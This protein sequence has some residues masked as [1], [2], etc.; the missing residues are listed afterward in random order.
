MA[1]RILITNADAASEVPG[2]SLAEVIKSRP[3]VAEDAFAILRS[4]AV[5]LDAMHAEGRVHGALRPESVV[6][7][8]GLARIVDWDAGNALAPLEHLVHAAEYLAPERL[9]GA[10]ASP[11]ADQFTLGAIAYRMRLGRSP[12]AAISLAETLFLIRYG[13]VDPDAYEYVDFATQSVFD[14]IFS[15][16]PAH[17]FGS[18]MEFVEHLEHVPRQSYSE[19]RLLDVDE[20]QSIYGDTAQPYPAQRGNASRRAW[21]L[22]S[23]AVVL[24]LVAFGLGVANRLTQREIGRMS[25]QFESLSGNGSQG[26]LH[27][28]RLEV[29]NTAADPIQIRE[30]AAAYMNPASQLRV[31]NSTVHIREGWSVAPGHSELLSWRTGSAEDWDGAVLFY[32]LRIEQAKKEYIVVGKWNGAVQEC[33]HVGR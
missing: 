7:E 4:L 11:A 1:T 18:C 22:W 23:A 27:N 17:R 6:M 5:T 29:C 30:V 12:F 9:T 31:F 26:S 3:P 24:S 2:M 20:Q 33:L 32:F 14:R 25:A 8:N 28:G 21:L 15:I 10:P 13:I 16:D 19:T